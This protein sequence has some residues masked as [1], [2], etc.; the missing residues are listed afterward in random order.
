MS[1]LNKILPPA[2]KLVGASK[3]NLLLSIRTK[4]VKPSDKRQDTNLVLI[5]DFNKVSHLINK[6]TKEILAL[7]VL[8]FILVK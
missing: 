8:Y 6:Y 5:N 1:L 7:M 3:A 4:V 2:E